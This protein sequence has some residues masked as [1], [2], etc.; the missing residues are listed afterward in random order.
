MWEVCMK[1]KHENNSRNFSHFHVTVIFWRGSSLLCLTMLIDLVC[2]K[3]WVF[4]LKEMH[5]GI[6]HTIV[7]AK[8]LQGKLTEWEELSHFKKP[9]QIKIKSLR[10]SMQRE[11][12][13]KI[14]KGTVK[15][16]I[17]IFINLYVRHQLC[18]R[19]IFTSG[20]RTLCLVWVYRHKMTAGG[21][22][23]GISL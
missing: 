13:K 9:E 21:T 3:F 4:W 14:S 19:I 16:L 2:G 8:I 17:H 22:F 18:F 20:T 10:G 1:S 15:G 6:L 12:N 23:R 11:E 5:A 7:S